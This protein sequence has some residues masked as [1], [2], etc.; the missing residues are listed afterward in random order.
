MGQLNEMVNCF[1]HKINTK[2]KHNID[3]SM[4]S[5]DILIKNALCSVNH[6][7]EIKLKRLNKKM[8]KIEYDI[9]MLEAELTSLETQ[10]A[11]LLSKNDKQRSDLNHINERHLTSNKYKIKTITDSVNIDV[12]VQNLKDVKNKRFK[13]L[14]H[15]NKKFDSENLSI[16]I[17]N[18]ENGHFDNDQYMNFFANIKKQCIHGGNLQE[19]SSNVC[20]NLLGL[21]DEFD[22]KILI[23]NVN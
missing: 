23:Q 18:I 12:I 22:Q 10:K 1:Q 3:S 9:K 19:L 6:E 17:K 5:L 7:E 8:E 11:T 16:W 13:E 2:I 15:E 21:K 4:H 14:E 20:L